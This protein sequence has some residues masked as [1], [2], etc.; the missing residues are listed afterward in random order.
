MAAP[1]VAQP[2]P[3]HPSLAEVPDRHSWLAELG[4]GP[5][6][7]AHP[8]RESHLINLVTFINGNAEAAVWTKIRRHLGRASHANFVWIDRRTFLASPSSFSGTR[9]DHML[10][11]I[12]TIPYICEFE[13]RG[14]NAAS[15]AFEIFTITGDEPAQEGANGT[16]V[17]MA[18]LRCYMLND[19][20]VD[21]L[22]VVRDTQS[23]PLSHYE[24]ALIVGTVPPELTQQ[25]IHLSAHFERIFT[26]QEQRE[27]LTLCHAN[28]QLSVQLHIFLG[29]HDQVIQRKQ[30]PANLRLLL[31]PLDEGNRLPLYLRGLARVSTIRLEI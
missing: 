15:V 30:G 16:Q 19:P 11:G 26:Y 4:A 7:F 3:A 6:H 18:I 8:K 28:V 22:C 12:L 23:P 24:V 27:I 13:A 29:A 31:S 9:L 25:V 2:A 17:L 14:L 21:H 1:V 5:F 20:V 10:A